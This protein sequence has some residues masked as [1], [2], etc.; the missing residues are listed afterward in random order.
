[1]DERLILVTVHN[2][3]INGVLVTQLASLSHM[4]R[5]RGSFSVRRHIYSLTWVRVNNKKTRLHSVSVAEWA[6]P[7]QLDI[8]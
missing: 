7:P 1:M 5:R 3:N 6:H 4:S 8:P 2:V